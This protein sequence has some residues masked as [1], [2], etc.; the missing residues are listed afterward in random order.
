MSIEWTP[1]SDPETTGEFALVGGDLR[2]YPDAWAA[3]RGLRRAAGLLV[4]VEPKLAQIPVLF[5]WYDVDDP[6]D[7]DG[8]IDVDPGQNRAQTAG[9]NLRTLD[10][11]A[12]F[13]FH[14][15]TAANTDQ[16]GKIRLGVTI[17]WT[18]PGNNFRVAAAARSEELSPVKVL[19]DDPSSRLFFDKNDN[20]LFEQSAGEV[21]LTETASACGMRVTPRLTVWRKLHVEV[22][23]MGPVAGNTETRTSGVVT[24]DEENQI[25]TV[26]VSGP[27]LDWNRFGGGKLQDARGYVFQIVGNDLHTVFVRKFEGM[28]PESNSLVTIWD[29][30]YLRDG[31][32]VSSPDCAA[33]AGAMAE[34]YITVVYNDSALSEKTTYVMGP[35][36]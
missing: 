29:D 35:R 27:A 18:Q 28:I 31:E 21:A 25:A 7:N 6:S 11:G 19:A 1:G 30:D 4:K 24:W 13:G 34:C 15:G 5:E 22:D 32:Q 17:G 10:W 2:F 23:D 16:N 12:E 14:P 20:N 36:P 3:G 33:L 8:P 9:D 26:P